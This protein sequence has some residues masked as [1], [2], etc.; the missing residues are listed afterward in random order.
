LGIIR[1]IA[2]ENPDAAARVADGIDKAA[3]ALADFAAGRAGRVVGTYEK[4]LSNLPN[5][6]VY[7]S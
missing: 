7:E 1:Y 3:A 2:Q 6:M 5:G 4:V